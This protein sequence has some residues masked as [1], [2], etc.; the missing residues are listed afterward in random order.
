MLQ[1]P[2]RT[3]GERAAR[4]RTRL[5]TSQYTSAPWCMMAS[6]GGRIANIRQM[7]GGGAML[8]VRTA[9]VPIQFAIHSWAN[10]VGMHLL[11]CNTYGT[12]GTAV[13][14]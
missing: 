12:V 4:R 8:V 11:L 7:E 13:E 3:A 6:S 14:L 1:C 9:P 5:R 10:T 2:S